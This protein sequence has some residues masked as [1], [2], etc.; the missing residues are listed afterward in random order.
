M[1]MARDRRATLSENELLTVWCADDRLCGLVVRVLGYRSR[2]R[3]LSLVSTIEELLGRNSNGSGLW[4]REYGCGDLLRWPRD[5]LYP[6]KLA[7]TSPTSG[8]RSVGIVRLWT[9]ATEFVFVCLWCDHAFNQNNHN[10]NDNDF[11]PT[12]ACFC[13]TSL[14]VG[15]VMRNKRMT[16]PLIRWT[17]PCT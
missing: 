17:Y 9:K 14:K 4:S 16:L 11:R 8:S 7:L 1:E 3:L 5:T 12:P 13:V 2:H 10:N 15:V 6:Q